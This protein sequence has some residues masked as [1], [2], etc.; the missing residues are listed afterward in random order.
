ME[1]VE[2]DAGLDAESLEDDLDSVA[3]LESVEGFESVPEDEVLS[4]PALSDLLES[5]LLDDLDA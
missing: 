3:G 4:P 1:L 5:V 2:L